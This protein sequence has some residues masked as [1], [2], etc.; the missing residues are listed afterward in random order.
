MPPTHP[1]FRKPPLQETALSVQ[2]NVLQ[3]LRSAHLGLLWDRSYSDQYPDIQTDDQP[4]EPQFERFGDQI[5]LLPRLPVLRLANHAAVRLRAK[6]K[7][8]DK[9]IQVQNGR[10]IVNW[11]KSG[12]TAYPHFDA[13][14]TE[15]LRC[16]ELL[17]TFLNNRSLGLFEPNQWEVTYVNHIEQGKLW[18]SPNDFSKLLPGLLG[19]AKPK[20]AGLIESFESVWR[21]ELPDQ[22]GR[23]HIEL[24]HGWES[25]D[26]ASPQVLVL[27]LTARG[28]ID[29]LSNDLAKGLNIGHDAIVD[30]FAQV[31]SLEAQSHWERNQ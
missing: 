15:L 26:T 12:A 25:P 23:L 9:M 13:S 6:S 5:K 16:T 20:G 30:T 11:L 17:K 14:R 27:Q 24:T 31:T 28:P 29:L 19:N 10:I 21:F 3:S 1:T 7:V 18:Q 8:G 22:A 2:F 4:I